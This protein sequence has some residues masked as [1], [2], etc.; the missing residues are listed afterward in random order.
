MFAKVFA[1]DLEQRL[2]S[3]QAGQQSPVFHFENYT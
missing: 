3:D 2:L 1:K